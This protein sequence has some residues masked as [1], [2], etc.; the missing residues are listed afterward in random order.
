MEKSMLASIR[1]IRLPLN[2]LKFP[3][4]LAAAPTFYLL[5]CY[6]ALLFWI[7]IS[8]YC[9]KVCNLQAGGLDLLQS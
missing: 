7:C 8:L 9:W 1:I 5:A 4:Y 3:A 2:A 6:F